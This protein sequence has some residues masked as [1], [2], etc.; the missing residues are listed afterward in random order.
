MSCNLYG[1][2]KLIRGGALSITYTVKRLR[3]VTGKA[4]VVSV[5]PSVSIE[6]LLGVL[7]FSR[8]HTHFDYEP[9]LTR[10]YTSK[11]TLE[12]FNLKFMILWDVNPLPI[13]LVI[14]LNPLS[15]DGT[16]K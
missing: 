5:L 16:V 2:L 3:N 13:P 8:N 15:L 1:L 10:E 7:S 12:S 11:V 9:N 14:N 6:R 4:V